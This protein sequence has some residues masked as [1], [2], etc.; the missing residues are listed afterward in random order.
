VI[1]FRPAA[2][3]Y[4]GGAVAPPARFVK[5]VTHIGRQAH[6]G[7]GRPALGEAP[8]D[9]ELVRAARA[10]VEW[11]QEG[12]FRRYV[13]MADRLAFRLAPR[14]HE[15]DDIVQDAFAEAFH[16]LDRLQEPAAF[17]GW[18]RTIVV[19]TAARAIRRE[20]LRRR[21]G[22]STAAPVD[23]SELVGQGTAPDLAVEL[24]GL[25]ARIGALPAQARIALILRRVEG[26][27]IPETAKEMGV[28]EGTVKRRLRQAEQALRDAVRKGA[29]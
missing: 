5:I 18:L 9:A 7:Q 25:Y 3:P 8:S 1:R 12:L 22:M 10:G 15:A 4:K 21:L 26:R 23:P 6:A 29:R 27:T 28:S 16:R 13:G 17:G 20:R 14:D 24:R 11:A 19:R 2:V